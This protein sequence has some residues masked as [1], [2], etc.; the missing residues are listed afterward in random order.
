MILDHRIVSQLQKY[1]Q[2]CQLLIISHAYSLHC[3]PGLR[4]WHYP[5]RFPHLLS[6]CYAARK[7]SNLPHAEEFSKWS[8]VP[9]C[10][11]AHDWTEV[12][13]RRK[14]EIQ[15]TH[16]FYKGR[17]EIPF[18][19]VLHKKFSFMLCLWNKRCQNLQS[20][21]GLSL[22]RVSVINYNVCT[23]KVR[24]VRTHLSICLCLL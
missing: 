17:R 23:V 16:Y 12:K 4:D 1:H 5:R 22:R 21:F 8:R 15:Y 6:N 14:K 10:S 18:W 3:T 20:P 24:H 9:S 19:L 7:K 13:D 2:T 11:F